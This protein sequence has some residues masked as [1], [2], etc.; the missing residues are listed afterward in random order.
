V[1]IGDNVATYGLTDIFLGAL[2]AA[3]SSCKT[4]GPFTRPQYVRAMSAH[5]VRAALSTQNGLAVF[6]VVIEHMS[7]EGRRLPSRLL[8]SS[9]HF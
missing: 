1:N 2:A 5:W 7:S 3:D 4:A 9:A 6:W 8:T